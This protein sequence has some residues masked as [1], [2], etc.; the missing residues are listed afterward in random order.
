LDA[1]ELW[2]EIENKV[3]PLAIRQRLEDTN[4]ELACCVYRTEEGL[5]E[6][7]AH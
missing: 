5:Q 1:H 3:V 6:M 7:L 4:V 2:P